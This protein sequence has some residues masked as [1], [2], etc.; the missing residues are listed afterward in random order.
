MLGLSNEGTEDAVYDSQAI[1]RF[2]GIDLNREAAPDA[3]TLHRA[4]SRNITN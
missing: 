3:A 4:Y 2:V 1:R